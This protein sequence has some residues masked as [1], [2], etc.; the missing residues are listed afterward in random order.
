MSFYSK[1]A[2][3]SRE[4]VISKTVKVRVMEMKFFPGNLV[5]DAFYEAWLYARS[6]KCD[7]V[8]K[9][10]GLIIKIEQTENS[11]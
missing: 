2:K 8:F 3:D 10:N 11:L 4:I 9:H 5:D 7:V 1:T 6:E